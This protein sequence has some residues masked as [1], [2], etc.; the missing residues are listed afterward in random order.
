VGLTRSRRLDVQ[1]RDR[2]AVEGVERNVPGGLDQ[3]FPSVVEEVLDEDEGGGLGEG[4]AAGHQH[5]A[6]G[7]APDLAHDVLHRA[8]P[9]L[10]E[11]VGGV[12]PRAAQ[13]A[14]RVAQNVV[15]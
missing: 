1:D 12:A 2:A 6:A 15:S 14:P 9:A 8:A 11:R 3:H 5:A 13:R 7:M 4:L 10:V